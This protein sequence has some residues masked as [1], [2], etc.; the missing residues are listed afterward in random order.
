MEGSIIVRKGFSGGFS[1][2]SPALLLLPLMIFSVLYVL[3]RF[4]VHECSCDLCETIV[5][6]FEYQCYI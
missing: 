4:L 5:I 3:L 6:S 1:T 2:F